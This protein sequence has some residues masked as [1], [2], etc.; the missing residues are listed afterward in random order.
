MSNTLRHAHRAFTRRIPRADYAHVRAPVAQ[1]TERRTSNPR[2]AGSNPAGRIRSAWKRARTDQIARAWIIAPHARGMSCYLGIT[3]LREFVT[4]AASTG[5]IPG[6]CRTWQLAAF[7]VTSL[8]VPKTEASV[9]AVPLQAHALDALDRMEDGAGSPLLFPGERGGQAKQRSPPTDSNRR[10]PPYHPRIC[11]QTA[12]PSSRQTPR[13]R[14]GHTTA[15]V[16]DVTG[17]GCF[18]WWRA[19]RLGGWARVHPAAR[20]YRASFRFARSALRL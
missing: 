3:V 2:V 1:W 16:L 17:S 8:Q 18:R 7:H 20:S 19:P 9:R 5:A 6:S 15:S 14:S 10:P 12:A 4:L 13:F 11:L